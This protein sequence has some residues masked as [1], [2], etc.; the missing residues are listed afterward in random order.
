MSKFDGI[1][2]C[3]LSDDIKKEKDVNLVFR[4]FM[5]LLDGWSLALR[6]NVL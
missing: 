5:D 6:D 2:I 4:W 3:K 1:V